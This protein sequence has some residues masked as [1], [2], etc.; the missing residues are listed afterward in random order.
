M[1]IKAILNTES[2]LARQGGT[3]MEVNISL[4]ENPKPGD[5]VIVH[6]GFAIETLDLEEAEDRIE[7][8]RQMEEQNS[9]GEPADDA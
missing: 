2:A 8:F 1:E 4:L 9:T 6:A 3:D 5:Y 7:L